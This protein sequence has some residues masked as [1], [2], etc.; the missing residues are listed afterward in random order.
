MTKRVHIPQVGERDPLAVAS[1]LARKLG[2]TPLRDGGDY[3]CWTCECR[4]R[5]SKGSATGEIFTERCP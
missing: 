3:A 4:G 5:L 2:H 1:D